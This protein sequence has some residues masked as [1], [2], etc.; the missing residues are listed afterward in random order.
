MLLNRQ[1]KTLF[2]KWWRTVDPYLLIAFGL[3][4]VIGALMVTTASPAVAQRIGVDYFHFTK[5]QFFF[6]GIGVIIAFIISLVEQKTVRRLAT[7]GLLIG[8]FNMIIVL[9]VGEEIKGSTRWIS[10]GGLSFQPSEFLKPCFIIFCAWMF[11][12]KLKNEKFPGFLIGNSVYFIILT[13]LV[14]QPD[15]GTSVI[16]T[17]VWIGMYFLSGL[18]IILLMVIGACAIFGGILAYAFLPH[19]TARIDKFLSP[20]VEENYQVKKSLEAFANGGFFG[21]GPGEGVVKNHIPDSHTDFIFAVVAEEMGLI[22]VL[23]VVGIFAF[24][25]FRGFKKIYHSNDHFT[26]LAVAGILMNFGLQAVINMGVTMKLLPT[27]G[28]TMPFVSYGGSSTVAQ[29]ISIGFLLALTRK[30]Y[31]KK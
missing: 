14:L 19:V 17:A 29:A 25:I 7:F 10:L 18:P 6:L 11:S 15:I 8:I 9:F 12:E 1:D 2:A 27:K 21:K 26:V 22:A 5:R 20:D 24:I 13:L 16:F 28:M 30:R 4:I 23:L 3:L 31:G